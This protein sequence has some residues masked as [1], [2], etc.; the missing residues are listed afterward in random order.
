MRPLNPFAGARHGADAWSL[1]YASVPEKL[2]RYHSD[3][4]KLVSRSF[5]LVT[6][7][8]SFFVH[9]DLD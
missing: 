9:L 5:G 8:I 3:G 7:S 2:E 6:V 4:F 1:L